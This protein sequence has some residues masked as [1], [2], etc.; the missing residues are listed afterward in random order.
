MESNNG[1]NVEDL[2]TNPLDLA[3]HFTGSGVRVPV[4]IVEASGESV[5]LEDD[6]VREN[7]NESM[8]IVV[9]EMSTNDGENLTMGVDDNVKVTQNSNIVMPSQQPMGM[10]VVSSVDSTQLTPSKHSTL[11]SITAGLVQDTS[12]LPV[13]QT[14]HNTGNIPTL[15]ISLDGTTL[16]P[17]LSIQQVSQSA[18][19]HFQEVSRSLRNE[20][21]EISPETIAN[22]FPPSLAESLAASIISHS[23]G[24]NN[25]SLL[26]SAINQTGQSLPLVNYND[27][28]DVSRVMS[29]I[30]P[31]LT[32]TSNTSISRMET[33]R[34]ENVLNET[35]LPSSPESN[36]DT[37]DLLN[38]GLGQE[39]EI[40]SK[41]ANAG[42]VGES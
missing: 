19:Q 10:V 11:S 8:E 29:N 21:I 25:T 16:D 30:D 2:T 17:Q 37:N 12:S 5:V 1:G 6:G 40:T 20:G 27:L 36:F 13:R 26:D 39:D 9:E 41:L 7:Q 14:T 32:T 33:N 23:T 18:I 15:G 35:D 31:N 22:H 34:M 42:P 38:T 4:E 24:T 28:S 3:R